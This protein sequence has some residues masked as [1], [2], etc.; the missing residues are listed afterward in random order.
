M[1]RSAEFL[2]AINSSGRLE[3]VGSKTQRGERSFLVPH[4]SLERI[5]ALISNTLNYEI[6]LCYSI[7]F[8]QPLSC[9][10]SVGSGTPSGGRWNS[11]LISS[12]IE[13]FTGGKWPPLSSS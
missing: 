12:L 11:L 4:S 10:K 5:S 3:P 1:K 9:V 2:T 8:Y 6:A 13:S 7:F